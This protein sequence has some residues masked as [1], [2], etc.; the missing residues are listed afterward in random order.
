MDTPIT[1][2]DGSPYGPDL[3]LP[4]AIARLCDGGLVTVTA[5]GPATPDSD[6]RGEPR[7]GFD[8]TIYP[9]RA[10][11][12]QR[13]PPTVN[14]AGIGSRPAADAA[15]FAETLTLASQLATYA[16]LGHAT[17]GHAEAIGTGHGQDAARRALATS[18]PETCQAIVQ[19][20]DD[21]DYMTCDRFP[22]PALSG[23]HGITY[24]ATDLAADLGADPS[25]DA[26][27]DAADAYFAAAGEAFWA[28]AER[29]A[30]DRATQAARTQEK[31][32]S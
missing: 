23:E 17:L 26:L 27:T 3:S 9:A 31:S 4:A 24:D 12:G 13:Q 6:P 22:T 19:H 2:R 25:S 15:L 20:L 1:I 5:I 29:I 30:R 28:E 10:A 32:T 14:W 18:A 21:G 16:S 11:Y 8:I 7:P